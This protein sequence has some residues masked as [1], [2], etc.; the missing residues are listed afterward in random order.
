MPKKLL[1]VL[2]SV[3]YFA[4]ISWAIYLYFQAQAG[5]DVKVAI[6]G[7][8]PRHLLAGRYV[9]YVIDWEKTDCSQFESQVC[10]KEEFCEKRH[11]TS[12]E[13]SCRFYV[14][15]R[16]ADALQKLLWRARN[17]LNFEVIFSYK[18]GSKPLAK[19]MLI[20]G[21]ELTEES[22]EEEILKLK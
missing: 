9:E 10:P 1:I 17:E 14:D 12:N 20:N 16:K 22:L 11:Y 6:Q 13:R 21:K 4:L 8:D 7:Y 19:K 2:F 15:E 18:K 5:V 3:P